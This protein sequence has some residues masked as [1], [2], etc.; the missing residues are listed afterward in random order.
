MLPPVPLGANLPPVT[1]PPWLWPQVY[2]P[3][4]NLFMPN[5]LEAA[6]SG[7][8]R[9]FASSTTG[10]GRNRVCFT[11]VD[12]YA[13]GLIIAERALYANSPALGGFYI[14]TDGATHPDPA[15]FGL[16]WEVVDSAVTRMGFPSLWGK[17][18]L[19]SWLLYPVSHV[20]NV[21]GWAMGRKLKLNPFNVRVLTMHR[22]FRIDAAE[23]DLRYS[24]I[25]GFANG[26]DDTCEWFAI[27]WL[28]GF[29]RQRASGASLAG[30]AQQSQDKI[31]IQAAK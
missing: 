2:G 23:K 28:P 4:D 24:P 10:Y 27:N 1:L 9:I 29:T 11:H 5:I 19:P 14:V 31:N 16:F 6:G 20:C 17:F 30:L 15:G 12:N 26:W 22:W 25:I 18:K 8:L 7:L 21:I 13:H 3:R